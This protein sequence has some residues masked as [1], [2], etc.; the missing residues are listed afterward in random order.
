MKDWSNIT[1]EDYQLMYGIIKDSSLDEIETD[2]KLIA[3]VN[4]ISEDD[5]TRSVYKELRHT[6]GFLNEGKIPGV[7]K[8]RVKIEGKTYFLELNASEHRFGRFVDATT[9]MSGD[10]AMV[11]NLHLIMASLAVPTK[12]NWYGKIVKGKY[13]DIPH[14]EV[15]DDM[16]K[17]NFADCYH[18]AVFFYKLINALLPVTVHY[19]V[20]QIL[21]E[22]K[23]TK[24]QIREILKPLKAGGDGF[25]MLNLLQDL[26][27]LN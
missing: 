6:I 24:S 25:T 8:D 5:I 26:N 27:G 13:S 9:F 10:D 17:L 11:A 1:I 22:G 14:R 7:V 12:K 19:S 21:K 15:A 20:K 18:T 2:I 23:L 3:F 16:L 4:N